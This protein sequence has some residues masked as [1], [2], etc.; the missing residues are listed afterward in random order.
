MVVSEDEVMIAISQYINNELIEKAPNG[1]EKFKIGFISA[2]IKN[3][4][5]NLIKTAKNNDIIKSMELFNENGLIDIDKVKEYALES[6]KNTGKIQ[7]GGFMFG[8][9][10]INKFCGILR[11]VE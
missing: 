1:L 9:S 11:G 7:V 8:E 6:I 5:K 10:D 3:N 2:G 4:A